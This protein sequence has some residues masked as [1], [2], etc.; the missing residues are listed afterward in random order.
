[1]K[2]FNL[3]GIFIILC[4]GLVLA[5]NS[6]DLDFALGSTQ[7]F[8]LEEGDEVRFTLK[9]ANHVIV[10][11]NVYESSIDFQVVPYADNSTQMKGGWLSLD[12]IAN[13][14]LEMDNDAELTLALYSISSEGIVTLVFQKVGASNEVTGLDIGEVVEDTE[15][16]L[17]SWKV[18]LLKVI[19]VLVVILVVFLIFRGKKEEVVEAEVLEQVEK[20]TE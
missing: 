6:Y 5:G 1:M 19:G 8:Y 17:P 16:D 3:I 12:T 7:G 11:N 2:L 10:L 13:I 15:E 20:K 4:S 9:D 18:T 14:D